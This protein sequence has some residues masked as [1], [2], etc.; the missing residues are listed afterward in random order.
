MRA[1]S[2]GCPKDGRRGRLPL[3]V[4]MQSNRIRSRAALAAA[5]LALSLPVLAQTSP[6]DPVLVER[7]N[8][9]VYRSEYEAQ[10]AQMPEEVRAGFNNSKQRVGKLVQKLIV[11]KAL[12]QEADAAHLDADPEAQRR[13]KLDRERMLAQ[14]RVEDIERKAKADFDARKEQN[15]ARARELY[16]ADRAKYS[17]P[18]QVEAS[19][20]LF[21]T[22][23]RSS[24][25]ARKLAEEAR[26]KVT[27]GGMDFNELAKK[28]SE[29]SSAPI[30]Q[31]HLGWFDRKTMDPEF[32]KA[33]FGLAKV[34]DVSAPVKSAFGWH[35]VKLE[36]HKDARVQPFEE[37]KDTILADMRRRYVDDQREQQIAAIR[38]DPKMVVNVKDIDALYT[39]VDPE[40]ERRAIEAAAARKGAPGGR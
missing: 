16:L 40:A 37:V 21:T 36:G 39:P 26:A 4:P 35:I 34:G 12:A 3:V 27:T 20:I 22:K 38:D 28:V 15:E 29:D 7:G 5:L 1:V 6:D 11:Q 33:A 9:K 23:T 30:N 31:G 8:V 14:L 2:R 19:H 18:E 13:L 32:T 25:E 24:D 10:L 17:F